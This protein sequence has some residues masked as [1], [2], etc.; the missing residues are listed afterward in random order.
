[1]TLVF[2]DTS[3][4]YALLDAS[5]ERHDR[6]RAAWLGLAE[7]KD[8]L[9]TSSYVLVEAT[10]LLG[11]RLG[12]EAVRTLDSRFAPLLSVVWVN[13]ALHRRAMAALLVAGKRNLSLVDCVSFEVMR[14]MNIDIAFAL[15]AHF[16]Q[17]GFTLLQ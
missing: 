4:L 7:Q 8:S 14:E 2:V 13:E 6:A 11:R 15:D 1:M 12:I 5:D 16:Q 17:Q 3:A 10:A 9:I